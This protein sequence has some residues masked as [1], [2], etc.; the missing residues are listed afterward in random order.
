MAT[1]PTGLTCPSRRP[2]LLFPQTRRMFNGDDP[3]SMLTGRSDFA[4]NAGDGAPEGPL[5]RGRGEGPPVGAL[6]FISQYPWW[7]KEA[8]GQPPERLF[9][10]ISFVC[11]RIRARQVVD[12]LSRTYLV[13][14][15]YLNPHAAF[16]GT[17][18]GDNENYLAGFNNDTSRSTLHP[19]GQDRAG[20][21][22]SD[23]FGSSHPDSLSMA[24]ADGSVRGVAYA[25]S[26]V[27]HRAAGHRADGR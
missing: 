7:W 18:R 24:F 12:G 15:K 9:S 1:P 14:E 8:N 25:V 19:P 13:G 10:G 20:I 21:A 17:D 2:A 5:G 22:F 4:I 6:A 27:V 23:R 26:P 16:S 11:S 3:P